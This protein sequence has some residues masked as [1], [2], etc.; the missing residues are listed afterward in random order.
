MIIFTSSA[1][2][3]SRVSK[4][5]FPHFPSTCPRISQAIVTPRD[6][7]ITN[8]Y[9]SHPTKSQT[10]KNIGIESIPMLQHV[11]I[12]GY[13]VELLI[14]LVYNLAEKWFGH[15]V[16]HLTLEI[17]C[18]Y[19]LDRLSGS[20]LLIIRNQKRSYN[21]FFPISKL[22][23]GN[24]VGGQAPDYSSNEISTRHSHLKWPSSIQIQIKQKFINSTD[25]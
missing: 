21:S 12:S 24:I 7:Q 23:C 16:T 10:E 1:I 14:G 11:Y 3:R 20:S 19:L 22:K 17:T 25:R 6:S 8:M 2:H 15:I 4:L 13:H 5:N 9:N 18:N